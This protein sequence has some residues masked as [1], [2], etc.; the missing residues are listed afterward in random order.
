MSEAQLTIQPYSDK[1]ILVQGDFETYSKQMKKFQARWNS[2]LKAGPGWLVPNE[3]EGALRSF[4]G[5]E[6]SEEDVVPKYKPAPKKPSPKKPAP[7]P[8]PVVEEVPEEPV[9]EPEEEPVAE[10]PKKP[11]PKKPTPKVEDDVVSLATKM[12][13]MMLRLEKLEGKTK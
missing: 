12:K 6:A 4:F 1:N 5:I 9:P 7:P 13:D 2:R 11:A 3:F 10:L 8:P